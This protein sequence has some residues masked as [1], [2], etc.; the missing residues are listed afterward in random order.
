MQR[1][2]SADFFVGNVPPLYSIR[3]LFKFS[4][5]SGETSLGDINLSPVV[6]YLTVHPSIEHML[7]ERHRQYVE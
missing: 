5:T 7:L 2:R 1:E 6:R 4:W 3:G